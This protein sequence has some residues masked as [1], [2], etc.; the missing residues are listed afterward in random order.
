MNIT[1]RVRQALIEAN[2]PTMT[3]RDIEREIV[4]RIQS[5][6]YR[7]LIAETK[8]EIDEEGYWQ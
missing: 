2:L 1:D 3:I 6:E 4:T 7:A 8:N 5:L